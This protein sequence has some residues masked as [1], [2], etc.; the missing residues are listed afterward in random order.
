MVINVVIPDWSLTLKKMVSSE[1]GGINGSLLCCIV[2]EGCSE[3]KVS[4][5]EASYR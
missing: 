5:M 3:V 4:E 1:R 2:S